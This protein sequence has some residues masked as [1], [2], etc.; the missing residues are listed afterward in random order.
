[1]NEMERIAAMATDYKHICV[2]LC[3]VDGNAFALMGT[4]TKALRRAGAPREVLEAFKSEA[5]SGDYDHVIQT[6]MDWVTVE[7]EPEED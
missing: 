3:G 5:M 7:F 2:N 6:I 1:V 4:V